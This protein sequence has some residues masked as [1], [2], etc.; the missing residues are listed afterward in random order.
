MY[1][2]C[3]VLFDDLQY[4]LLGIYELLLIDAAIRVRGCNRFRNTGIWSGRL[5]PIG[6]F[7]PLASR[8][9]LKLKRAFGE[10]D[11]RDKG[12]KRK[13]EVES[14]LINKGSA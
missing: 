4:E 8:E 6:I 12:T 14:T 3:S 1:F 9:L 5:P 11:R 10:K 7:D 2:A 13:E